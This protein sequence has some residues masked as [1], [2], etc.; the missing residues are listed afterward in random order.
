MM[1][2]NIIYHIFIYFLLIYYL[3]SAVAACVRHPAGHAIVV[4]VY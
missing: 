2:A 4:F 1:P 3:V